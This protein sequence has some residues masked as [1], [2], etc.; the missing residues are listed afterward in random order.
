[1][2]LERQKRSKSALSELELAI[3]Y[4]TKLTNNEFL[5]RLLFRK[6]NLLTSK[7]IQKYE[8][9]LVIIDQL[10]SIEFELEEIENNF[11]DNQ[12]KL[13]EQK[14]NLKNLNTINFETPK[15]MI[16]KSLKNFRMPLLMKMDRKSIPEIN[17][18][19][20]SVIMTDRI[21]IDHSGQ[22][23]SIA[24]CIPEDTLLFFEY[25]L[26]ILMLDK[27]APKY[28]Q[29]CLKLISFY[30]EIH[31][32]K[33]YCNL[34]YCSEQCQT[35]A[36]H[37]HRIECQNSCSIDYL[38]HSSR[39]LLRFLLK[40]DLKL[41][42]DRIKYF[43][44]LTIKNYT[45]EHDHLSN[46][47]D[48]C[49]IFKWAY[50][51]IDDKIVVDKDVILKLCLQAILLNDFLQIILPLSNFE[52]L[53]RI[54]TLFEM[55]LL[56]DLILKEHCIDSITSDQIQFDENFDLKLLGQHNFKQFVQLDEE[57]IMNQQML[58]HFDNL[59]RQNIENIGKEQIAIGFY[60]LKPYFF[61]TIRE[62]NVK[63]LYRQTCRVLRS[64]MHLK[65]NQF[66][67]ADKE[68][69]YGKNIQG[70]IKYYKSLMEFNDN[71]RKILE[72]L[73]QNLLPTKQHQLLALS[74]GNQFVHYY[75]ENNDHRQA[76][77]YNK[78]CLDIVRYLSLQN[79][80]SMDTWNKLELALMIRRVSFEFDLFVNNETDP[81]ESLQL[82]TNCLKHCMQ[83]LN[84]LY[85]IIVPPLWL[86]PNN[87]DNNDQHCLIKD[88]IIELIENDYSFS[89][90]LNIEDMMV[91]CDLFVNKF[92]NFNF[93]NSTISTEHKQ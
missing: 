82:A 19:E 80:F 9:A 76:M 64:K 38:N 61:N 4:C 14:I 22:Q 2:I 62:S 79:Y 8:E 25:P 68:Y 45:L 70:Q 50:F 49:S 65:P 52:L 69:F 73:Y 47:N 77:R 56:V 48:F 36:E 7:D 60:S 46:Y 92:K 71:D 81:T 58:A 75:Q 35:K 15:Q 63:I 37:Y 41:V 27:F 72:K 3:S 87:T 29:N 67:I 43:Q 12:Q 74:L 44:K 42:N 54:A 51:K 78:E 88:K 5:R 16:E 17:I 18:Q 20:N 93:S 90:L 85:G 84:R 11:L 89:K 13:L 55:L 23:I 83:V 53:E 1:M 28:C 21:K 34:I 59:I 33:Y 57:S 40:D 10:K 31:P 26:S 86:W 66:V 30:N 39:L 6:I 24:K 91:A 32:C